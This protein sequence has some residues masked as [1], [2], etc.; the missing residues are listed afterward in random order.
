VEISSAW[1]SG[2]QGIARATATLDAAAAETSDATV[3]SDTVSIGGGDDLITATTD[4]MM[5][6]TMMQANVKLLQTAQQMDD[7]LLQLLI[8]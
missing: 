4:R 8:R 7:T 3:P 5:A 6:S 2:V 1:S